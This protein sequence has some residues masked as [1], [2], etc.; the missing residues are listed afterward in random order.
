[1]IKNDK[2]L[3]YSKEWAEKFAEANCKLRVN[4]EKRQKD[5]DG[6]QL[7]Q[8]SNK[9]LQQKLLDE[10][11]EYEMLVFHNPNEPI[12]LKVECMN[13]ISNLLIKARIAF[14]ITQKE[15]AALC[16]RTEE[17]IKSFEDKD[18]QNASFLDFLAVADTLGVEIV[19]GKFV[20]KMDDFYLERLVAMRQAENV[21][22]SFKAAS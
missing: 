18:Y 17:Q 8:D 16:S 3:I 22:A 12:S 4:E 6:W 10:I 1:M 9:A 11:A 2:Q 20:A 7:I 13:K 14:K 21:D 19:D 5:P 15:L